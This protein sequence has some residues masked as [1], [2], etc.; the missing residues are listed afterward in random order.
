MSADEELW[1]NRRQRG[2][3]REHRPALGV[4]DQLRQAAATPGGWPVTDEAAQRLLENL[5]EPVSYCGVMV[6]L[7]GLGEFPCI[8][9]D[10][11]APGSHSGGCVTAPEGAGLWPLGEIAREDG[12][13]RVQPLPQS[14][15]DVTPNSD[16]TTAATVAVELR[17]QAARLQAVA[18]SAT[19]YDRQTALLAAAD[20]LEARADEVDPS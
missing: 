17:Q 15:P 11:G 10:D 18:R 3:W 8:V 19:N 6:T 12:Q 2:Y 4:L 16:V 5:A 13:A 7:D 20:A 14:W 1:G 9:P